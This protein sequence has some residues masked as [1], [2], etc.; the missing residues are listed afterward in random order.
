MMEKK[1]LR[2]ADFVSAIVLLVF[3]V[4]ML[5]T[6]VT[7][8]P[9]K[10]SWGGVK[11]VWYV[12]P[13][14][15]PLFIGAGILGLSLVLLRNAIKEG[16]AATFCQQVRHFEF[17]LSE[18]MLR[19]LA[20]V[21]VFAALVYVYIPVNDFFLAALLCLTVFMSMFHLDRVD[22][23]KKC[24]GFFFVVSLLFG[25]AR[26][27]KLTPYLKTWYL[28]DILLFLAYLAYIGYVWA[29]L[30]GQEGLRKKFALTLLMSFAVPLFVVP[31]FKYGLLVPF[32][33][34]GAAIEIM[35]MFWYAPAIK[36][37]RSVTGPY[38]L[39]VGIFA[40]FV[41]IIAGIHVKFLRQ[42]RDRA[43]E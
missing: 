23:L 42:P 40:V 43:T 13:A 8:F 27:A 20:I 16:G 9:M 12:S 38:V 10:G 26:L 19:F 1:S 5:I 17:R 39:L 18:G 32:P 33:T 14:L 24:A 30:G 36:A 6:T 11:N 41:V 35:N 29:M 22:L 3:A 28:A 25:L 4:W 37:A 21:L 31:L 34:E 2:S 7:T 15:L